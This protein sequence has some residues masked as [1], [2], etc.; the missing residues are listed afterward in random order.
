MNY[1]ITITWLATYLTA[2]VAIGGHKV[3]G[4]SPF[5]FC[6]ADRDDDLLV[7]EKIDMAPNPPQLY[8]MAPSLLLTHTQVLLGARPYS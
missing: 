3:P 4:E 2:V 1:L 8:V 6:N 5:K 7:V